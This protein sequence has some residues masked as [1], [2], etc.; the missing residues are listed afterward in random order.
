MKTKGMKSAGSTLR[1]GSIAG[2]ISGTGLARGGANARA[3]SRPPS[4]RP[5]GSQDGALVPTRKSQINVD[6][7]WDISF[8]PVT[9]DQLCLHKSRVSSVREFLSQRAWQ[10]ARIPR[11]VPSARAAA[12]TD[13]L[14]IGEFPSFAVPDS[15]ARRR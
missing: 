2:S 4:G 15:P 10:S 5:R 8:S 12:P 9:L 1:Q 6:D 13:A 11:G 14:A 7:P 3:S